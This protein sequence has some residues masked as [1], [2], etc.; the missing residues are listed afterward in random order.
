MTVARPHTLR[1]PALLLALVALLATLVP[2]A[3]A[4]AQA[5]DWN[6]AVACP[7]DLVRPS[8]FPD[9]TGVHGPAIDCLR[10]YGLTQGQNDGTYGTQDP[11]RRDAIASFLVRALG[12]VDAYSLP[13]P[14]RGAFPDVDTGPHRDNVE[15]LANVNPPIVVG[16]PDGS[17]DPRSNMTRA[18]FASVI[19]RTLDELASDGIIERL[20]AAGNRFPDTRGSVH[21]GNIN[22]LAAAGIIVGVGD[23]RNFDPGGNV[24]RGQTATIL[25]RVLGGLVAR[26]AV[27][28][29]EV[30]I[31]G[32]VN[33]G[34]DLT[35][36]EV[37]QDEG[38]ANAEVTVFRDG[39]RV[40]S[41]RTGSDGRYRIQLPQPGN[42]RLLATASGFAGGPRVDISLPD[43]DLG[44]VD[45]RVYR[46]AE[47]PTDVTSSTSSSGD[48]SEIDGFW[49]VAFQHPDVGP[50]DIASEF[51]WELP[52]QGNQT[53]PTIIRL[54]S[55]GSNDSYWER[56]DDGTGA[57]ASGDHI[58]YALI[59]GTWY[60]TTVRFSNGQL[61]AVN[62]G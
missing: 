8:G 11:V 34:T 53:S 30:A 22:R 57:Y 47:R 58:I 51:R 50:G 42:Y 14:R 60:E 5:S 31:T 27:L 18:Q 12:E 21:E 54:G 38:I 10:W 23:G 46:G 2:P 45:L 20:P 17:Y 37:N 4:S 16:R 32:I 15:R 62:P 3:G 55:I 52:L 29:P 7:A 59:D 24:T 28:L 6:T 26:D 40:T 56:N 44:T 19:A 35:P 1:R 9:A 43:D 48:I 25:A 33:D 13:G 36:G 41:V 49:R 39:Q 61:T